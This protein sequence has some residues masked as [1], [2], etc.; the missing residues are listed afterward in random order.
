LASNV[1]LSRFFKKMAYFNVKF[2]YVYI[3]KI[4]KYE[5]TIVLKKFAHNIT[6]YGDKKIKK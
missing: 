1:V 4:H 2:H 5:R 6:Q 3:M